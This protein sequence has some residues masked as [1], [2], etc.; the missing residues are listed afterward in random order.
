M[1][2]DGVSYLTE[3]VYSIG[4]QP[5]KVLTD[6]VADKIAPSYWKPNTDI[7]VSEITIKFQMNRLN[8][9]SRFWS[10]CVTDVKQILKRPVYTNIIVVAVARVSVIH[11][12]WIKFQCQPVVG[13]IQF[14]FVIAVKKFYRKNVTHVQVNKKKHLISN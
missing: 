9:C 12:Q 8:N 4:A 5:S 2:I 6:W 14:V 13:P 1:V 11:V 7:I 3:T 10:R